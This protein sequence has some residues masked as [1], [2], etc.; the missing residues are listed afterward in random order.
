[1]DLTLAPTVSENQGVMSPMASNGWANFS[2][3]GPA[4]A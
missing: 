3:Y 2:S 1:M 4:A